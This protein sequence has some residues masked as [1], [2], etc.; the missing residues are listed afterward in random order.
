MHHHGFRV[1][2]DDAPDFVADAHGHVPPAFGPGPHA[3]RRPN[4]GVLL[5]AIVSRERHRAETVR[6]QVDRSFKD[7][8]LRTPFK[9]V[10]SQAALR[11][12]PD[13]LPQLE[14]QSWTPDSRDLECADLSALSK[15]ATS[16]RTPKNALRVKVIKQ[17]GSSVIQ[18]SIQFRR[19]V[20]PR[21][22][23]GP[24]RY[25][26]NPSRSVPSPCQ[27]APGC[28]RWC[29][30][31]QPQTASSPRTIWIGIDDLLKDDRPRWSS[32]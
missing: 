17:C 23:K 3:T 24:N 1:R 7:R 29:P 8:K 11:M 18:S 31:G 26:F 30:G 9:K 2:A 5:Q 27:A 13:N 4:V 14:N 28:R 15:A 20:G 22:K 10:V 16:R 25:C 19:P 6:D 12:D 21:S 32:K